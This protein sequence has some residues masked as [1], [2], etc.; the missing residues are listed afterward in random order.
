MIILSVPYAEKD[1]AKMLGAKWSQDRKTWY[2]PDGM[3]LSP[4][5]CWLSSSTEG[6]AIIKQIRK[7]SAPKKPRVDSYVAATTTGKLYFNIGHDCDPF[8]P[9]ASCK[10]ILDASGWNKKYPHWAGYLEAE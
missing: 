2:V 7:V 8:E 5:E 10:P 3:L 9:C 4:F 1:Q 6:C